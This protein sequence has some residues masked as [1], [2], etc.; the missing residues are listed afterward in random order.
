[1][2]CEVREQVWKSETEPEIIRLIM[3]KYYGWEGHSRIAWSEDNFLHKLM[4][5]LGCSNIA[6]MNLQYFQWR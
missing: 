6:L 5:E 1:M 3:A 2:S 4:R